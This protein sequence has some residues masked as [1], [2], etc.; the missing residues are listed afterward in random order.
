VGR[1]LSEVERAYIAGLLDAD[2]AIMASIERHPEK[3]YGFRVRVALKLTQSKPELLNWVKRKISFGHIRK[4][5]TTYDWVVN[6]QK[7]I[8]IILSQVIGFLRVKRKQGKLAI[9]I[10]SSPCNSLEDL[11][12]NAQLADTLAS[13]NVRSKNR[14][15]NFASKIQE[16]VPRND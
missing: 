6:D 10:L 13:F 5:R 16:S 11:I 1:T 9:R 3:K 15:L 2:G 14:R 8:L 7:H 4:N 12:R